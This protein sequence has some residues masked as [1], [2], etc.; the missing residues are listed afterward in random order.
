LNVDLLL[1]KIFIKKIDSYK[2]FLF[3]WLSNLQT[4]FSYQ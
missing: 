4:F 2:T 1:Q 3:Q